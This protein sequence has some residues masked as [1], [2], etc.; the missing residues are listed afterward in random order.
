MRK[1]APLLVFTLACGGTQA[2]PETTPT[3]TGET[4]QSSRPRPPIAKQ[5]P[6]AL[7]AHGQTRRDPY[8][9][10]CDDDRDDPEI[11]AHL[12]AAAV[13]APLRD[14]RDA[15]YQEIVGRI[16]QDDAS[17]PSRYGSHAT[18]TQTLGPPTRPQPGDVATRRSSNG[19]IDATDDTTRDTGDPSRAADA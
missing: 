12:R 13:R 9:W 11:L 1:L 6:H 8:Y 17:V 2:S 15:L 19:T 14:F 10:M 18:P 16:P 4:T 7:E 3:T 5:V